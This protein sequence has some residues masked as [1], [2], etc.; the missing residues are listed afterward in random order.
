MSAIPDLATLRTKKKLS[1]ERM[2][3]D[4][5]TSLGTVRNWES[6]RIRATQMSVEK[7]VLLAEILDV[8]LEYLWKVICVHHDS[9]D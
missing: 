1:P 2:A 5:D 9:N 8:S 7:F 6:K 3:A 4:L